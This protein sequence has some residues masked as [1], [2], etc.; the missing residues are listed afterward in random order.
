MLRHALVVCLL[1]PTLASA[2]SSTGDLPA[3]ADP[4]DDR[5][6]LGIGARV[7]DSAYA[8]EGTRTLPLPLVN[9][10][11]E[12]FFWRGVTGG[13]HLFEGEAF[14]LEAVVSGRFDGFD[15]DDLGRRELLANG[16]DPDWLQD[17]DDGLDVG[18]SARWRGRAGELKFEALADVADASGGYEL[19]LDYGYALHWGRTTVVPGA[20]VRWM[21]KD[22]AD[23]YYGTLDEEAAL[24][25]PAYRPG[26]TLIPRASL[27]F[28]HPLGRKWRMIGAVKYEF[29]PGEIGDSPLIEAGT[30]GE[31]ALSIGLARGF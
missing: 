19:S 12:R 11:G 20:G 8:G 4:N 28:S 31:A 17:R 7:K 23:Y 26:S 3:N 16:L 18:L 24:G 14:R 2:Q 15:I 13:F 1:F 29:L 10:E 5:W 22:M 27:G 9:Y 30:D 21:S 25:A 6:S